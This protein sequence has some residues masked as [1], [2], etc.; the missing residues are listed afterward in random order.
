[1]YE[2]ARMDGAGRVR[3]YWAITF[4]LLRPALLVSIVINLMN[5]FNSFP[6]I[7]TMTTGGPDYQ[8]STSTIYMYSLKEF[9]IGESG[10]LSVVNFGVV[11]IIVL[12][13][14]WANRSTLKEG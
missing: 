10:A 3:T 12:A 13:F 14:L 1:V 2:A 6:I 9:N 11:I 5:V 7:W 4:P 8:T